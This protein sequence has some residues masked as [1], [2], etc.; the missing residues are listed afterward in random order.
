MDK[1]RFST[2]TR[3]IRWKIA[4]TLTYHGGGHGTLDRLRLVNLAGSVSGE[5]VEDDWPENMES[6]CGELLNSLSYII[7]GLLLVCLA[8]SPRL[9]ASNLFQSPILFQLVHNSG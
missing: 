5:I 1:L 8:T 9:A 7:S 3:Q 6:M 2:G 4:L